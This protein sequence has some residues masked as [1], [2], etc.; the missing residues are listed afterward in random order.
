R[1]QRST[2]RWA[3]TERQSGQRSGNDRIWATVAGNLPRHKPSIYG[4]FE[5][6]AR[7][8]HGNQR[9]P[10]GLSR[11]RSRVRVPS[12]PL[13]NCVHL[14]AFLVDKPAQGDF[15][16]LRYR[17]SS[18]ELGTHPVDDG[19]DGRPLTHVAAVEHTGSLGVAMVEAEIQVVDRV[20]L[21]VAAVD[22]E[23]WG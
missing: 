15:P 22:E 19:G 14:Q 17:L 2:Y 9:L 3:R 13:Q 18:G 21:V 23:D 20:L 10:S 12:L 1:H 11:R 4:V 16:S 8:K 6:Q 5:Q 7:P